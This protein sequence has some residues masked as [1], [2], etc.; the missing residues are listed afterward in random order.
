[1]NRQPAVPRERSLVA[2][3]G[4][5]FADLMLVIMLVAMGGQPETPE[6]VATPSPATPSTTPTATPTTTPTPA[7]AP[8]PTPTPKPIPIGPLAL[9]R[10][11]VVVDV[12]GAPGATTALTAQLTKALAPYHGRRAGFVLTFGWGSNI[13]SDI[14]YATTVNTLLGK[15]LPAMFPSGTVLRPY[16]DL[17]HTGG[18]AEIQVFFFAVAP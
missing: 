16:M 6:A 14:A 15:T 4:W 3:A 18:A 11:P 5:L 8:T 13:D 17:S 9:D 1:V 2:F 7:P 10:S 12:S